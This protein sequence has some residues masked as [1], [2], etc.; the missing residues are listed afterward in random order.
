MR[1]TIFKRAVERDNL[2]IAEST[3][4]ELGRLTLAEALELTALV[5][6]KEPR[7]AFA[8]GSLTRDAP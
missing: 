7:A 5:A 6:H 1:G 2:I 8:R 4:R 3:A